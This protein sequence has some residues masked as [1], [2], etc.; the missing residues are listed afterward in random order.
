MANGLPVSLC[1]EDCER[2]SY[3]CGTPLNR[4]IGSAGILKEIKNYD[5]AH[6]VLPTNCSHYP[7]KKLNNDSCVYIGLFG[8]YNTLAENQDE[9]IQT[10]LP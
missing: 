1:R 7:S 6:L 5:F 10:K 3:E 4:L 9:I 2:L 8:E